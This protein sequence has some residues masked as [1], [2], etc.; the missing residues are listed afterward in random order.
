MLE[1]I[2]CA[3]CDAVLSAP[4]SRVALP[5]HAGFSFGHELLPVLMESGT[6][7]VDPEPSGP[8]WRRW[9]EIGPEEAAARGVYA[10]VH[11]LSYGP[12]GTIV[13]APGD[14]RGTAFVPGRAGGYCCGVSGADGPNL[15]CEHCGQEVATLDDDCSMWQAVWFLEH[16]VRRRPSGTARRAADG[17]PP[18]A[19]RP[20]IPPVDPDGYWDLR[21]EAAAG[22]ALAHLLAA[23]G[24]SPVTLPDGLLTDMFGRAA[25]ALL[26]P[27]APGTPAKRAALAGPGLPAPG[28]AV[29]IALIPR[30]PRTGEPCPPPGRAGTPPATVPL[31]AEIWTYL[32]FT[33]DR[34]LVQA[35]GTLPDE[36]LRD[37]PPPPRPW[38]LFRPES[39]VFL[40]TLARLPAVRQP[41]LRAIHDRVRERPYASP[42]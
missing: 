13:I 18:S 24:G 31:P 12:S 32:A 34:R 22:A 23:S 37:D 10:P 26:P 35:P 27:P 30:H 19:E 41:W 39:K 5:A 8:P 16:A 21:W 14:S 36:A 4:V 2:V 33:G 29:D 3:R 11:S 42:F 25:D 7:A 40:A 15:A 17:N 28:P 38:R 9:D 6:Y 1:V 20:G